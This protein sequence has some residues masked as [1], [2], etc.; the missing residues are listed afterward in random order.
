MRGEQVVEGG[1]RSAPGNM[2][3][4][5]KPLSVLIKHRVNNVDKRLIAGEEAMTSCEQIAF[6]PALA[7]MLAEDFHHPTQQ[8]D[9]RHRERFTHPGAIG[10]VKH[11]T[12]RLEA[13]RPDPPSGNC[14][15]P[16]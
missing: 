7:G 2:V 8:Q 3:A 12:Q 16:G 14:Y 10:H 15:S 6:Q 4:T 9:G 5:L 11:I 13:A 1:D